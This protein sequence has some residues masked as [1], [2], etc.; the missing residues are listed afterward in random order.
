MTKA[1][2]NNKLPMPVGT[3]LDC[4]WGWEQTNVDFYQV[5][6]ATAK[7]IWIRPIAHTRKEVA[8]DEY[9]VEPIL[10]RFLDDNEKGELHRINKSGYITMNSYSVATPYKGGSILETTYA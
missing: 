2:S 6:R 3:I 5:V 10:G 4:E 8:V 1:I 7:S 9:E